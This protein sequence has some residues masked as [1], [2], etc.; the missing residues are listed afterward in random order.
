[1]DNEGQIFTT[2]FE[3]LEWAAGILSGPFRLQS[4]MAVSSGGLFNDFTY[5]NGYVEHTYDQSFIDANA[6]WSI[7][8]SGCCRINTMRANRNKYYTVSTV[9]KRDAFLNGNSG[10]TVDMFPLMELV[11]GQSS[12]LVVSAFSAIDGLLSDGLMTL[13]WA[14]AQEMCKFTGSRCKNGPDYGVSLLDSTTGIATWDT[15]FLNCGEVNDPK[16]LDNTIFA[17]KCMNRKHMCPQGNVPSLEWCQN[18]CAQYK[19]CR[20][21][22]YQSS[23]QQ[24]YLLKNRGRKLKYDGWQCCRK[25]RKF[26]KPCLYPMQAIITVRKELLFTYEFFM[27]M[28]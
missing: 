28:S 24:C 21:V 5:A 3:G 15:R 26:A 12:A 7:R 17:G 20:F 13:R 10:P 18:L 4:G 9:V 22:S 8:L 16:C 25:D 19:K 1:M 2:R 27:L 11:R 14:N 6:E 23:T